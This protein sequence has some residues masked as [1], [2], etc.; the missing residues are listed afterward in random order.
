MEVARFLQGEDEGA[1]HSVGSFAFV[2]PDDIRV[3]TLHEASVGIERRA[4]VVAFYAECL[5]TT[6]LSAI[7]EREEVAVSAKAKH[8]ADGVGEIERAARTGAEHCAWRLVCPFDGE[9]H[10]V[11]IAYLRDPP[12]PF[13]GSNDSI[14]WP[15]LFQLNH[16]LPSYLIGQRAVV[17]LSGEALPLAEGHIRRVCQTMPALLAD[18]LYGRQDAVVR[19]AHRDAVLRDVVPNGKHAAVDEWILVREAFLAYLRWLPMLV[20]EL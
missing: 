5:A 3:E 20:E 19:V 14:L 10:R 9:L 17:E 12:P 13:R 2:L 6:L 18:D 8:P 7:P 15:E 11:G 4:L 16:A 1:H